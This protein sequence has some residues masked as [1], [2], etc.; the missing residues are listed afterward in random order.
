MRIKEIYETF[1]TSRRSYVLSLHYVFFGANVNHDNIVTV[2][3]VTSFK[4]HETGM[5]NAIFYQQTEEP[6][7]SNSEEQHLFCV[8]TS[9]TRQP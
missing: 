9:I 2:L 6:F 4:K 5:R 3:T 7:I 8:M 1:I